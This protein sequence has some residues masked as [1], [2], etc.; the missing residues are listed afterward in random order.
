MTNTLAFVSIKGGVGKTTL[1]LETASALVNDFGKKVLLVDANFSAPNIGL[2]LDLTNEVTLHDALFGVGLH[3][4]IYESHGIDIVPASMDYQDEVDVFKLKKILNKFKPRYDFIIIDSS[5][6]YEE[7]KPVIAAADKIFIVTSPDHVTLTTSLKAAKLA[8]EQ[9]TP[10]EGMIVNKIRSP[11]HEFNLNEIENISEVPV[12]ARIRDHKN[13]AIALHH[14]T[15]ITVHDRENIV[16][17][18]IRKFAS[19]ICGE[20]EKPSG[21]FQ[22]FLPFRGFVHK[23]EVNRE[24][25]RKKFYESQL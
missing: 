13:M 7:L 22:R 21:F 4:A 16:S 24:M 8:R 17:K 23:D 20:P 10:V 15:P 5:P 12:M 11:R 19:A 6:N 25:L 1:A 9:E 3:N 18:E 14:K 2:Y